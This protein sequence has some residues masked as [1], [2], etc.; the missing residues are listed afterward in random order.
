M[1]LAQRLQPADGGKDF[2]AA[3]AGGAADLYGRRQSTV[4]CAAP[5]RRHRDAEKGG[6]VVNGEENSLDCMTL[7]PFWK[8]GINPDACRTLGF[9]RH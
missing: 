3:E 8:C 6:G 7:L 2:V 9:S 1:A 5:D 4:L